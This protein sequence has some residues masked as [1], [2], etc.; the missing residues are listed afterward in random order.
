MLRGIIWTCLFELLVLALEPLERNLLESQ[1]WSAVRT[2]LGVGPMVGNRGA[3]VLGVVMLLACV[4]LV[5]RGPQASP[6]KPVKPVQTKVEIKKIVQP[7]KIVRQTQII[8]KPAPAPKVIVKH[9]TVTVI[10]P[11]GSS[12]KPAT[13]KTPTNPNHASP[14][15]TPAPKS[16]AGPNGKGSS[17]AGHKLQASS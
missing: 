4:G 16:P 13:P 2:R 3:I 15:P 1:A 11:G 6:A 12:G 17:G 7:V 14:A 9:E 10:K 8:E 5:W